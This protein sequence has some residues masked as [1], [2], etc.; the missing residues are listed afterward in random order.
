LMTFSASFATVCFFHSLT[1]YFL[2]LVA[3]LFRVS[4]RTGFGRQTP[5]AS[6]PD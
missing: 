5:T 4:P 1:V 3:D 6:I 2:L